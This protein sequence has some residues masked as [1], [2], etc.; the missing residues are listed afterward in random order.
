MVIFSFHELSR[1]RTSLDMDGTLLFTNSLS[2][3]D[4]IT[5]ISAFL[6]LTEKWIL[7]KFERRGLNNKLT[8]QWP[9]RSFR[10]FWQDMQTLGNSETSNFEQ[11]RFLSRLTTGENL[12]LITSI[13]FEKFKFN[14]FNFFNIT[15]KVRFLV[16]SNLIGDTWKNKIG[17]TWIS[18]KCLKLSTPNFH[19]FLTSTKTCLVQ[20]L[21]SLEVPNLDLLPKTSNGGC[22]LI[23]LAT[24]S[25]FDKS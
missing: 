7:T 19:K 6:Q 3:Q 4:I 12:V 10:G 1:A 18:Q 11:G 25:K 24:S 13:P 17:Q 21:K 8:M 15:Y 5:K 16:F 14:R 20:N 22:R 2:T 9:I 23:S